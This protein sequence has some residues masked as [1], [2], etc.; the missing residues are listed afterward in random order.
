MMRAAWYERQGPAGEVLTV[1]EVETPEPGP[2]EVRI[3]VATSGVNPSDVKRRA[4][5]RR[6]PMG[7]ARIIPH[8]DGAGTIDRV[9]PG[10]P[11]SRVGERVWTYNAQW[12]RPFGTAAE[13]VALP[14]RQAIRLPDGADFAA[15]ACL[16][17]PG[18]TAHRCVY[19]DG[20]V[21]G[22]TVLVTG[23]AGSVGFYAAQLA[24]WGGATVIA[25][26]SSD[27]KAEHARR[28]G[29]DHVLNYR[30]DDVAARVLELT[31]GR[32]VD[33]IVE[34]DFGA[35][36]PTSLA[37]LKPHGFIVAYASMSDPNPVLPF[38]PLM[39][40]NAVIR[41]VF[42]YEAGPEALGRAAEDLTAWLESGD[43]RHLI[44]A[45]FPLEEIA[46]VHEAVDSGRLI[47][48][49]VVTVASAD[50]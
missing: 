29:A 31:D 8:S 17:I 38:Y 27:A 37:V 14:A 1:G 5:W 11:E 36:L 28:A 3:R 13:Y 49:V 10:V 25:T 24:K 46:A 39:Q 50:G 12:Q 4:G 6:Q 21:A 19:A 47:G 23:G 45:Q 9:G 44:A 18:M 26:V 41:Q 35:N 7:F 42:I 15:G 34:V 48:N 33:R 30:T 43:A 20:P 40:R 2:G 32:G 22:R 16:G